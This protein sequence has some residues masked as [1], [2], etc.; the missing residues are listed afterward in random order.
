MSRPASR[1]SRLQS[2]ALEATVLSSNAGGTTA[3][4]SSLP[5]GSIRTSAIPDS[6]GAGLSE[7]TVGDGK[8]PVIASHGT[9]GE[10]ACR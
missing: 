5:R 2:V 1:K 6:I 9:S 4:P 8:G 3:S 7:V 10:P